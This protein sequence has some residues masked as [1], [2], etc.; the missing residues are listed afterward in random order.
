[1]EVITLAQ[2]KAQERRLAA[3]LRR[4]RKEIERVEALGANAVAEQQA[5]EE[6]AAK[7]PAADP[8]TEPMP[9]RKA[10]GF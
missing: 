3:E 1:M 7:A 9:L 2:M 10:S 8:S 5:C 4:L 6:Q